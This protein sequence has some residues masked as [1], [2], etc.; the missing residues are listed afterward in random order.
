M[1][2]ASA[3]RTMDRYFQLM[4]R[5]DD[6]AACYSADATWVIADTGEVVQGAVAVRDYVIALHASRADWH[7]HTYV[8]A[9]GH[10]YLEGDCAAADA[11]HDVRTRYCVAYDIADD[12]ISAMRCYGFGGPAA[13]G[14]SQ[15]SAAEG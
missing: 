7:T 12:L 4:G 5:G 11:Q 10:A 3:Q 15:P 2:T 13:A 9:D 1:S 14:E 8:V 6:I